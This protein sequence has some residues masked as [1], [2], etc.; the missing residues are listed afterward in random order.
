MACAEEARA[1]QEQGPDDQED[2]SKTD[3][4]DCGMGLGGNGQAVVKQLLRRETREVWRKGA[5]LR[6]GH[7]DREISVA[8]KLG[9]PGPQNW[10]VWKQDHPL[11][12]DQ[13][14][15]IVRREKMARDGSPREPHPCN[16][17]MLL[18]HFSSNIR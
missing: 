8:P 14:P 1:W 7:T 15:S 10:M 9:T 17:T 2:G 13:T 6:L 18:S 16:W 4:N 12:V 3:L 5:E 11:R